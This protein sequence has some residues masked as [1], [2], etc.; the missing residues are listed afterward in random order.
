M[1]EGPT[2]ESRQD[3]WMVPKEGNLS[4]VLDEGLAL[5]AI[6]VHLQGL[7]SQEG[8]VTVI[9]FEFTWDLISKRL[10]RVLHSGVRML[11]A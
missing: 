5:V 4:I 9:A 11:Q 8:S 2:T 6:N 1:I 7:Q 3:H 10:E